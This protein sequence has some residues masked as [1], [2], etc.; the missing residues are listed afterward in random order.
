MTIRARN[1][2]TGKLTSID[3]WKIA[4]MPDL[5]WFKSKSVSA[6]KLLEVQRSLMDFFRAPSA[7]YSFK[8][9]FRILITV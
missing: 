6:G 2:F 1:M 3:V 9:S 7:N 4:S 8:G 5:K